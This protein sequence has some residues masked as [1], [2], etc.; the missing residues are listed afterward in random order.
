MHEFWDYSAI[1]DG[2]FSTCCD[3]GRVLSHLRVDARDDVTT[4][5]AL[6]RGGEPSTCAKLLRVVVL[7]D[8]AS[9][10]PRLLEAE[11]KK[12]FKWMSNSVHSNNLLDKRPLKLTT[13][14]SITTVNR[15]H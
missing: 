15:I 4:V 12:K 7:I 3:L 11:K 8:S 10:L 5:P 14:F 13:T 6:A 1:E 9:A 2:T